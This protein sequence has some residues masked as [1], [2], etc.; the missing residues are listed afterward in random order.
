M[1]L[2]SRPLKDIFF[3]PEESNFYSNCIESLVLNHCV[4]SESITE[5]GS[6]DGTP[7]IQALQRTEFSGTIHGFEINPLACEAAQARI[8]EAD[9]ETNYQ[10]H[11]NSFFENLKFQGDYIISNPPYLPAW[12]NQLYQPLLHGGI[13][14]ITVT[15]KLLSC[16]YKNVL[17][18]AASYSDPQGLVDYAASQDYCVSG[19]MV[20]PLPFGYYSSDPKVMSRIAELRREKRA[21]YTDNLY[22]LAG[23]LFTKHET[24]DENISAELLSLMTAL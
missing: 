16:S 11:C 20:S 13:D 22:L 1:L 3:C 24:C 9:L 17:V 23:V 7:V 8:R 21:F 4:G 10:V 6:G 14:G 19:F 18:M 2:S 5:F 15:K 12:D